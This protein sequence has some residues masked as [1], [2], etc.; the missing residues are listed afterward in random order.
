MTNTTVKRGTDTRDIQASVSASAVSC[1][2]WCSKRNAVSHIGEK[3]YAYCATCANTRR[4]SGA[5]RTRR[6]RSWELRLLESG[7]PL[8]S[9]TPIRNPN[10]REVTA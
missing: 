7:T 10:A 9:Y 6:M 2:G 1:D 5:E 8:P 4:E 3:G